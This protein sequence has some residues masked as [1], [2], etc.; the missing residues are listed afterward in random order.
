MLAFQRLVVAC[1]GE[2]DAPARSA[3]TSPSAHLAGD[4]CAVVGSAARLRID[5]TV[6]FLV[7]SVGCAPSCTAVAGEGGGVE[8]RSTA[9]GAA[10]VQAV[11]VVD[12][13]RAS[14][15]KVTT[16]R[17][18]QFIREGACQVDAGSAAEGGEGR[19]DADA[20]DE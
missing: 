9:G 3:P 8:V 10:T 13:G 20:H 19:D 17:V 1:A 4:T 11:V 15:K 16:S 5:A 12:D 18:V 6:P 2:D 7:E 14:L